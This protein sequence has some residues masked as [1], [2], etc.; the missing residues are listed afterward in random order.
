VQYAGIVDRDRF[1]LLEGLGNML[2]CQLEGDLCVGR[3]NDAPDQVLRF[4]E[5]KTQCATPNRLAKLC[6]YVLEMFW[7]A[8]PGKDGLTE[9]VEGG[10]RGLVP[11]IPVFAYLFALVAQSCDT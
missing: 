1:S 10:Q 6:R 9:L 8:I 11:S 2:L 5:R 7:R 3:L 4:K